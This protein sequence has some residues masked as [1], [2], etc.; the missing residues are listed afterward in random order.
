MTGSQALDVAARISREAAGFISVALKALSP[1]R[2]DRSADRTWWRRPGVGIQYQIE[3][4]P[5]MDWER[6]YSRFNR[7]MMDDEGRLAF[8]GPFCQ[9]EDWVDLSSRAGADYHMMEIKWH[10]GICYF[11]TRLTDWKTPEDY[12]ARFAGAS[13]QAGIPFMFYYSSIFDHNPGF[14]PIQPAP[15]HTVSF[16]GYRQQYLDYIRAQY[17]EIMDKYAPDGMWIDWYWPDD[18]TDATVDLFRSEY[19]GT[20]LAFSISNYFPSAH[21]R[22]DYTSSEAHDL[23]G[24]YVRLMRLEGRLVPVLTGCWKWATLGRRV[25]EPPWELI[26]PAGRW[27]QD[28]TLRDDPN[29]LLR[30]AAVTM[31]NGGLFF[32]GVTSKLDG[33]IYPDQ[34]TQLGILGDWYSPR[35]H[36]FAESVPARYRR[37]EPPCVKVKP[38]S[39]KTTECVNGSDTLLHLFNMRGAAGPVAVELKGVRWETVRT[40]VLEPEGRRL[41]LVRDHDRAR[42]VVPPECCDPVDTILRLKSQKAPPGTGTGGA[43]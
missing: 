38:A 9:V 37:R 25:F 4:R 41:D 10:D 30:M 13:R 3:Y 33:G 28:P 32:A 5:G 7:S 31:A 26:A 11:D 2:H 39:F 43:F 12:A 17:R 14:D 35:K 15:G 21:R 27:W 24:H 18:A 29:E 36:L 40:V 19:P 22:L 34:V 6:D 1:A 42:V 16:I 20:V 23:E 8:N